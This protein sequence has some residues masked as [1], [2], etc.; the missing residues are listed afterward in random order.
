MGLMLYSFGPSYA[1]P[2]PL[3]AF[4][5][6]GA[7][8]VGISFIMMTL[9]AGHRTGPTAIRYPSREVAALNWAPGSGWLHLVGGAIGV[10]GLLTVIVT[11]LL[12]PTEPEHNL[13]VYLTWVYFWA[14][15]AV[16]TGLVGPLWDAV[17]PFRALN[18]LVSRVRSRPTTAAADAAEVKP[19]DRLAPY[20]I[21]PAVGLF[22]LFGLADV[23]GVSTSRPWAMALLALLYTVFTIYGMQR[24]GARPWLAHVEFFS[25]LFTILRRFAPIDIRDGRVFLRPIGAGLLDPLDAGWDWV[26]FVILMLST[27]AFDAILTTSVWDA[28]VKFTGPVWGPLGTIVG[29]HL[30]RG[31]GFVVLTAIFLAAF[32]ACMELVIYFATIQ[33]DG[34]ATATTF[35]LTLVPIAFVYNF[36]HNYPSLVVQSQQVIPL[37]ADPFGR[38]W[39]LLP[40]SGYQ[41]SALLAPA[42]VVWYLQVVLIVTGH[43]IAMWLAHLRAGERFRAAQSV[44]LSQYPILV[45]MVLY[46]MTSLW[47]LAQP[48]TGQH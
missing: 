30:L 18:D 6:A 12:G 36:A 39:H 19:E 16:L 40:T 14:G 10:L 9:F 42:A 20:G 15:M 4:Q 11:G 5:W 28:V 45:L 35:A 46:T 32:I 43:V 41:A 27:L 3:S 47:I 48:V 33:V 25:V 44:L 1:L 37:L 22:F 31:L 34:L 38:G 7:A 24:F 2:L 8:V 13:A 29:L 21:W 26:V 17:N 23:T